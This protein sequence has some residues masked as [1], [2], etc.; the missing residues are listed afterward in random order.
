MSAQGTPAA[1]GKTTRT[2]KGAWTITF[3]LFLFMLVNF[4]DKIVVG[5]AGVPIMTD[6]KLTPEQFGLLGSSFFF[7]FSIAA[8]VVGFIVNKV[9]TRWVLLSLAVVWALAQFPMVGTVSFTTLLIC[10]IVLGAGEGPAFSVAA[11]AIYK[12]F[13]DEKRTLPTA[14][15]SQGSAFGVILA[16]PALNWII[17]NHSWHYAFGA[18][19]VVGLIWVAAWLALGKEGPLEDTQTSAVTEPKIPY[20]Q[21]LTSRTFIGCVAATFGAY[22]ALSLGLTWF[23]P[24]IVKGLGFSQSQAGFISILPWVFGATIVILTGWISQVMMARGYNTRVARGVLGSVPLVIG[25]LILAMMPHV[26]GAG[27][28]I[29]LLVVGSGLCGAIYVVCPPMLGEFTPTSQ[30]GAILAIYGALYT[31]AGIIAPAVMGTVIQRAGSTIDGYMTGFTINAVIMVCSGLLGLLLL[32]PN[33]ERARLTRAAAAQ[34][35][36]LKGAVSPT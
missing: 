9:P 30:R 4:A 36:A 22:W 34:A 14:I 2:P 28:Q 33:T 10:R 27:L 8:I 23:T 15:L 6:L 24:F 17:V 19:G 7:L 12:W 31:L 11:H 29:A 3:L 5:L 18:L 32:W 20:L 16:V 35:N 26:Q 21:L 13:P 1:A 25:G